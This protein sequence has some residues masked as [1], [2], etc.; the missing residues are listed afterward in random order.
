MEIRKAG[1]GTREEVRK[2]EWIAENREGK[3]F[4]VQKK[5]VFSV[6]SHF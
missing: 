6:Q 5:P 1:K 4:E 2:T 3:K